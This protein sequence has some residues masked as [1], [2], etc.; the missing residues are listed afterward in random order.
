MNILDLKISTSRQ[1][2]DSLRVSTNRTIDL[3][4]DRNKMKEAKYLAKQTSFKELISLGSLSKQSPKPRNIEKSP[5][6]SL[7]QALSNSNSSGGEGGFSLKQLKLNCINEGQDRLTTYKIIRN[8]KKTFNSA[9]IQATLIKLE[10]Q[11]RAKKK[12][13]LK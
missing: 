10:N 12:F 13:T 8:K 3:F 4:D 11:E 5:Y 9:L 1:I 6:P 2:P 7:S